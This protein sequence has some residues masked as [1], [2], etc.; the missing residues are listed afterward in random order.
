MAQPRP[1]LADPARLS[2]TASVFCYVGHKEDDVVKG[3]SERLAAVLD[4][5]VVVAA[6]LHWDNLTAGGIEQVKKN[7]VTLVNRIIAAF[8]QQGTCH[9]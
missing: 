4:A 7:V 3:V 8:N 2:A 9:V 5:K 6:G 1:S